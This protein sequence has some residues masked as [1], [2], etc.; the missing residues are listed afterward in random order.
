MKLKLGNTYYHIT[1]AD[2]HLTMPGVKP[3]IYI[4]KNI[5]S[6]EEDK[7]YFQDTVSFVRFGSAV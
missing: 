7:E 1:Y 6:E 2:P 4:G 3:I 5:L